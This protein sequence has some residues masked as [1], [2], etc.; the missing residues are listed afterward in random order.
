MNQDFIPD[1]ILLDPRP[2]TE[3]EK[4][5][6]HEEMYGGMPANWV[7]KP[8]S[9]WRLPSQRNQDGSFSC[10][11]QSAASAME[12]FNK[13]VISAAVYQLRKDPT[14]EGDYLQDVLDILYNKGTVIEVQAPS[15]NM[16]DPQI[17]AVVLPTFLN[18]TI[19]GYRTIGTITMEAIAE[20]VQAYG[21]C[22]LVFSSNTQE[23][24]VTPVYNGQA[25]TFGHAICAVD[26]TLIN[27]QQ[28]LVARDSAGQFS[29]P[30]GYRLLTQDFLNAR[31]RGAAYILG[32][33]TTP[34]PPP[35][36]PAT[37]PFLVDMSYGQSSPE[38][39]RLQTFL[40]KL[41]FFPSTTPFSE[42]Y[43]D[44]TRQSVLAFQRKYVSP[45][46]LWANLVVETNGGKYCSWR[47]RDA[48]NG[49][50]GS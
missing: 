46:S 17:D 49:L 19:T 37:A 4:D 3:Q 16:S 39:A 25:T 43:G 14:Q 22:I 13:L 18:L 8:Q 23:W 1:A 21:N 33:K 50:L 41:G 28:R 44:I 38:I 2:I 40:M 10:L 26:F 30:Q 6:T 34:V 20:A 29:S 7:E 32:V 35:I 31:C 48:L 45:Q 11:F 47:T 24:Q 27:G 42:H 9:T 12:Q 15:Q 36:S 5:H